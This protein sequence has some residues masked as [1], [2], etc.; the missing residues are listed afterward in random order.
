MGSYQIRTWDL[1]DIGLGQA[2]G[3]WVCLFLIACIIR[4]FIQLI[5]G[6]ARIDPSEGGVDFYNTNLESGY[7]ALSDKTW[8]FEKRF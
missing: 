7:Q 8:I 2:S 6:I 4:P 5:T 1:Q 3:L